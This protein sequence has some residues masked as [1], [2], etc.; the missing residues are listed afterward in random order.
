M[1]NIFIIFAHKYRLIVVTTQA[2]ADSLS[3]GCRYDF[4][5]NKL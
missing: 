5:G 3:A 2:K 1:R 4:R